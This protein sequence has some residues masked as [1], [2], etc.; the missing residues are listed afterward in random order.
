MPD[1]DWLSWR[2]PLQSVSLSEIVDLAQKELMFSTTMSS[3][4]ELSARTCSS[5]VGKL[6]LHVALSWGR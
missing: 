5:I 3:W 6:I 4:K 1:S 2:W